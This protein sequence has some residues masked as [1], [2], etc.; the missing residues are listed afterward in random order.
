MHLSK[1]KNSILFLISLLAIAS[2][3]ILMP[4]RG[5]DTI[6]LW[7][8][9][10]GS[11]D[12]TL[13][14]QIDEYETE[15]GITINVVQK[16]IDD[17]RDD[18]ILAKIQ[19][20]LPDLV[21]LSGDIMPNLA[22]EN[23]LDTVD[24]GKFQGSYLDNV[25]LS[26]AFYESTDTGF[27]KNNIFYYGYPQRLD[28]TAFIY[29]KDMM[30][31]TTVIPEHD[32]EWDG[33]EFF[34]AIKSMSSL[35]NPATPKYGFAYMD[36][37]YGI[38]TMFN[39][40][41]G[42]KFTNN[43]VGSIHSEIQETYSIEALEFMFNLTLVNQITPGPAKM[44][45]EKVLELF[46]NDDEIAS[47]FALSS[48]IKSILDGTTF[49]PDDSNFGIAPIFKNEIGSPAPLQ[50][51]AFS[52]IKEST[53]SE[54][55]HSLAQYLTSEDSMTQLAENEGLIPADV[56]ILDQDQFTGDIILQSYRNYCEMASLIPMHPQWGKYQS[57]FIKHVGEMLNGEKASAEVCATAIQVD[58]TGSN[59]IDRDNNYGVITSEMLPSTD[60][61]KGIPGSSFIFILSV[62]VFTL[63]SISSKIKGVKK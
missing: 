46:A 54:L 7:Y 20:T 31:A 45:T 38:D 34:T 37:P 2:F 49:N 63:I 8:I 9:D 15:N 30:K 3:S 53:H 28:T 55:A 23:L 1:K 10:D 18:L 47:T 44:G 43:S 48:Q 24:P 25:L 19:E 21:Q 35:V 33:A 17:I 40:Y 29:N 16:S 32:G 50:V 60:T 13:L 39:A 59:G 51:F 12:D 26:I 58:I 22:G 11:I 27:N 4:V 36:H 57:Y 5:Q 62:S 42:V 41:G 56:S 61:G 14:S 52:V 6:T